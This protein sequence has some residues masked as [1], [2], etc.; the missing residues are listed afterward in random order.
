[1]LES[2]PMH[3][4]ASKGADVNE[5]GKENRQNKTA[6]KRMPR[7]QWKLLCNNSMGRVLLHCKR[8]LQ[9]P[10]K[11]RLPHTILHAVNE[12]RTMTKK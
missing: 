6:H 7:M 10:G 9:I 2:L 5:P 1:M 8:S 4:N 12:K 11:I 3:T